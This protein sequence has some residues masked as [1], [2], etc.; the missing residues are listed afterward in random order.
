MPLPAATAKPH[1]LDRE[2]TNLPS[3]RLTQPACSG[4][5]FLLL[6]VLILFG[7]THTLDWWGQKLLARLSSPWLDMTGFVLT[8]LGEAPITGALAVL[9]TVRGWRRSREQGLGPLL[10]FVG[11]GI[12]V[13]LK[14]LLPHPG[15][16]MDFARALRVPEFLRLIGSLLEVTTRP[17]W[18][19]LAPPYA[20]PSGHML[21]ATFLVAVASGHRP[22]WRRVGS[23]L[24]LGMGVTRVY[25]NEHWTSDVVGGALLGWAL[26]GVALALEH[27]PRQEA[28]AVDAK[29]A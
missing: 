14:S 28:V 25:C 15:P 22:Q 18:A 21:R 23:L 1:Y 2:A 13:L 7:A 4:L 6:C 12:E 27:A 19:G 5:A 3:R 17:V 10:L 8:L 24:V 11:V 16:P 9:L 29:A 20:F 26:A